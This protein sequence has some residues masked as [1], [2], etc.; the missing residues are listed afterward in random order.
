M[1]SSTNNRGPFCWTTFVR[2]YHP[3]AYQGKKESYYRNRNILQTPIA[4]AKA[5][6]SPV[7]DM[8]ER[9]TG[10]TRE[11]EESIQSDAVVNYRT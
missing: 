5:P 4:A 8:S 6:V 1:H 3:Q 10:A 9:A 11:K 2:F 7:P